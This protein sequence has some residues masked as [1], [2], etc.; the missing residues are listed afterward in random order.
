MSQ[1]IPKAYIDINFTNEN[2][3]NPIKEVIIGPKNMAL[4]SAISVY[5]ETL[6]IGNVKIE[7]S[8]SSYR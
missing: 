7:R 2:K 6:N 4:N 1:N 5:L 3:I 8:N